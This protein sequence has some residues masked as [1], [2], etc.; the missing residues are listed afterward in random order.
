MR[1]A[2][3]VCVKIVLQ[4]NWIYP[5]PTEKWRIVFSDDPVPNPAPEDDEET[6]E[7]EVVNLRT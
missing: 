1:S 3:F 5:H 4:N 6:V 2:I 7:T